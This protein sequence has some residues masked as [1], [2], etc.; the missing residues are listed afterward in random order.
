MLTMEEVF[1]LMKSK[2]SLINAS[3]IGEN[4]VLG[5]YKGKLSNYDI[6]IKYKEKVNEKWSRQR[7]PKHIHWT[8]D[9]LIKQYNA[10]LNTEKLLKFLL[11]KWKKIKGI[12]SNKER[13]SILT[14]VLKIKIPDKFINLNYGIYN[15][16]FLC[17]LAFLLMIQEKT[18]NSKA[19][20]FKK[21]L[22]ALKEKKDLFSI[23]S[24]ATHK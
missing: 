13:E 12:K 24:I 19:F 20:M 11:K 22:E 14:N 9:M 10:P 1:K 18:N 17:R 7:T 21:L 15:I 3:L 16:E 5:V 2:K 8:V 23:I 4:Y 6:L